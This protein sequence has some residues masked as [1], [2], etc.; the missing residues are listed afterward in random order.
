M[1]RFVLKYPILIV[2]ALLLATVLTGSSQP[3]WT[4]NNTGQNHTI[5]VPGTAALTIDGSVIQAGDYI[6]VFYD[7]LGT[8]KCGGY[9]IWQGSSMTIA[10][11]GSNSGSFNGFASNEAFKWKIWQNSGAQEFDCEASYNTV[12]FPNGQYYVNNGMSGLSSL[13]G[14][15]VTIYPNWNVS[16]TP[17]THQI[18]IPDSLVL[19]HNG[20]TISSDVYLGVFYNTGSDY[21]CGGYLK[22]TGTTDTLFAYGTEVNMFNGFTAGESFLWKMWLPGCECAIQSIAI[23]DIQ[24]YQD[25]NQFQINGQ[26][27]LKSLSAFSGYDLGI[28]SLAS[29]GNMCNNTD[30]ATAI[31][32][33]LRNFSGDTV[34]DYDI[35]ISINNQLTDSIYGFADTLLPYESKLIEIPESYDFSA[36]GNYSCEFSID[37]PL[38]NVEEND[39][40]I[41]VIYNHPL[42]S[43]SI[44]NQDTSYC[45][46]LIGTILLQA[47]PSGGFFIGEHVLDSTL[48]LADTGSFD[49][50]YHYTDLT[51]ACSN[52]ISRSIQI[53]ETPQLN[54]PVETIAC[55]DDTVC[56]TLPA[57]YDSYTWSTG[58]TGI[59]E[60]CLSNP[61]TYLVWVSTADGCSA[62]DTSTIF[63]QQAPLPEILG[64]TVACNGQVLP[65]LVAESFD[66]YQ[67]SG[68]VQSTGNYIEASESGIYII[69]VW[70]QGCPGSDTIVVNIY[71]RTDIYLEGPDLACYG[72][73]IYLHA[74][75]AFQ[76]YSWAHDQ[77]NF[78]DSSLV[79][80][81]GTY[82]VTGVDFNNCYS[83]IEYDII[84]TPYPEIELTAPY[85]LCTGETV[86][87]EPGKAD[88]Y[89]WN[90][91]D[92]TT[93]LSIDT[94]GFYEVICTNA[95]CEVS[96]STAIQFY[97]VPVVDFDYQILFNQVQ[98]FNH[99]TQVE[100]YEWNF[101]NDS[102]NTFYEPHIT[103]AG[104]GI[105]M[106]S[107]SASNFC[108]AS[109]VIQTVQITDIF[110]EHVIHNLHIYPN[111]GSGKLST[112]ITSTQKLIINLRVFDQLGI[113]V[114]S[115]NGIKLS[116]GENLLS[117]DFSTLPSGNYNMIWENSR[118]K[119]NRKLIIEH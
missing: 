71:P 21:S 110:D 119:I 66:F 102:T 87:L 92:T 109:H 77:F 33:E 27:G 65:L 57:G 97:D 5:L 68:I 49:I 93:T 18:V 78:L 100:A 88:T 44:I 84:F 39:S 101:G 70:D 96:S 14:E 20:N 80:E 83:N 16:A 37:V 60:I 25:S 64:D 45:Q 105:Y 19:M 48:F 28:V 61:G 54:L 52:E 12:A 4:Y 72:D 13:S 35:H 116:I 107:L 11:W 43:L 23:Y 2:T 10:A 50:V 103:Y 30:T 89:L 7:S 51:T 8:L 76:F 115:E 63:F 69:T 113:E 34:P 85:N 99:S 74:S 6:G 108:G 67:W 15:T 47:V 91:G 41:K 22:W 98:F 106:V 53:F 38:D 26:S 90:T 55:S 86:T 56:L 117:N 114:Y 104:T 40:L 59:N 9:K 112:Y 46:D 118:L 32:L 1:V 24:N 17:F 75:G 42:P 95:G 81:S 111:P 94:S 29:P 36:T 3:G 82:S 31:I 79:T 62:S 73:R 58:A